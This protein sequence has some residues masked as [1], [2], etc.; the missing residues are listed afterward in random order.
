VS[1]I[2][3]IIIQFPPPVEVATEATPVHFALAYWLL[4]N[5]Q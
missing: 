5:L 4:Q 1:K 2:I 3:S